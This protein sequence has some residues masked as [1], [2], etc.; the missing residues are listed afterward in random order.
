ALRFVLRPARLEPARV[1][2]SLA[3][4]DQ[5]L[6]QLL[7]GFEHAEVG[8]AQADRRNLQSAEVVQLSGHPLARERPHPLADRT[9]PEAERALVGAAPV[10]L[11]QRH[12]VA[13]VASL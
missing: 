9:A 6:D 1:A 5:I 11:Y 2:V 13:E 10:G 8:V 4:M 7:V 12:V 3:D